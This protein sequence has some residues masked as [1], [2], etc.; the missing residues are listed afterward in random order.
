MVGRE[1]PNSAAI[2]AT[3]YARRPSGSGSSYMSWAILA[4][5]GVILAFCPPVRPR[6]GPRPG[7]HG[8]ALT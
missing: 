3:V 5:R 7:R 6:A 4:W 8:C 2:W 1:T